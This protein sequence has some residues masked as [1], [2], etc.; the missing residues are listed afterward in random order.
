MLQKIYITLYSK[1]TG[2]KILKIKIKNSFYFI[3]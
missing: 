3:K 2:E 1:M